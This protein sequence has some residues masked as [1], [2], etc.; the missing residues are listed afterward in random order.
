MH[1]KTHISMHASVE[2]ILPKKL[3][4]SIGL[5]NKMLP[6]LKYTQI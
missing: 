5:R 2:T 6:E 1:T 4:L 3:V